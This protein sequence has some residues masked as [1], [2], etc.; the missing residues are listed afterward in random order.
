VVVDAGACWLGMSLNGPEASSEPPE[1]G[2]RVLN[3]M[4]D[5]LSW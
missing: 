2:R 5:I 1:S 3:F 4:G